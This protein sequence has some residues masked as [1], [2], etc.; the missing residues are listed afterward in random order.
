MEYFS[1]QSAVLERMFF[2]LLNQRMRTLICMLAV[3][4]FC[5]FSSSTVS[6]AGQKLDVF[7][8]IAPQKYFVQQIGKE[9]VNV[10]VMVQPG[11]NPA[12]YEPRPRQMA[13]LSKAQ[14]YFAIGVAFEK[15]WLGKIAAA[16]S[17]LRVVHTDHGVQKIPMATHHHP[18]EHDSGKNHQGEPDPH[19]WLSPTLVISQAR[20]ILN[21]LVDVDSNH[22]PVYEA[23]TNAFIAELA[24]LDA[25]FRDMFAGQQG[26]EFMVFHPAWGY[27]AQAYGL[28]QVP[29]EIEGK[30]PKPAQLKALIDHAQ[31]KHI[32]V[33]F[34]QPQFSA[35]SAEL[36]AKAIDGQ[37]IFADP[38]ASD[39]SDNL[40][41]VAQKFKTALK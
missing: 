39:W 19:T 32:K 14:I 10:Q 21:A 13:A 20:A 23:N 24:A 11:A 34:V 38:L 22:R 15:V 36:I 28:K 16:S 18:A 7:V 6:R 3:T 4:G 41:K 33:I 8:S 31:K 37:V 5:V 1:R 40:R 9:R 17:K 29:V 25:D 35:R 12:T 30:D 26:R 2:V 27:F